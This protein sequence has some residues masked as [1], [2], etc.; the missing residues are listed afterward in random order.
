MLG[1]LASCVT[2]GLLRS[3][4]SL[5]HLRVGLGGESGLR[6]PRPNPWCG[7]LE[8]GE[9]PTRRQIQGTKIWPAKGQVAHHFRRL[10][11]TDHLPRGRDDPDAAGANA[12][13]PPHR[14]DFEA[15]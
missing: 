7:H 10:D 13:H 4:I 6:A 3:T 5:A 9:G 2:T 8:R 1:G 14:I 12:P 11:N 15:V